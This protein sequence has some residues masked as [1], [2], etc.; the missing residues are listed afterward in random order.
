MG[1]EKLITKLSELLASV[2]VSDG[3]LSSLGLL[4]Q[5]DLLGVVG[6]RLDLSSF[7]EAGDDILVF[8]A[9]LVG[10]TAD[11]AELSAWL[12]S[13]DTEGLWDDDSL[14][15]VVWW[16]NALKDLQALQGG[17]AT[18]RLVG[19]HTTDGLVEDTG[20]GAEV[21]RTLGLVVSGC[22]S[23]VGVVLELVAEELAR[24]VESLT[25]HNNNVLAVQDLLGH[26]GGKTSKEMALA[27][28]NNNWLESAHFCLSVVECCRG[29]IFQD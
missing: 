8:P 9:D 23:E 28:D 10:E 27:V 3:L 22:L 29:W 16:R 17:L 26:S 11:G 1:E 25:S 21:E 2:G 20:W 19:D 7:F 14:V 4:L 12:Q 13:E 15:T 5:S 24:D 6:G 18:G